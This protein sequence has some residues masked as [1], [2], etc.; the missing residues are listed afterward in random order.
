VEG[1]IASLEQAG[2]ENVFSEK[3][4][5]VVTDRRELAKAILLR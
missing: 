4:S 1:Q 5:G 2:A 3:V